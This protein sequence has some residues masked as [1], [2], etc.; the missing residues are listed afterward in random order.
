MKDGKIET[1][2]VRYVCICCYE[3]LSRKVIDFNDAELDPAHRRFVN[4][5][6]KSFDEGNLSH[7]EFK[8]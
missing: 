8:H 2:Y 1:K 4:N 7:S 6:D 3:Y 5:S